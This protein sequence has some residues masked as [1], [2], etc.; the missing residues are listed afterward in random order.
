MKIL[1]CCKQIPDYDYLMPE[2]WKADEQ[3]KVD[4]SFVK[5]IINPCDE[6]ALELTLKLRDQA[7]ATNQDFEIDALSIGGKQIEGMLKS[8]LALQFD[9]VARVDFE[10]NTFSDSIKEGEIYCSYIEKGPLPDII[11]MGQYNPPFDNG[12]AP[13]LIAERLSWP[14][15]SPVNEIALSEETGC[16]ECTS[17]QGGTIYRHTLK[18]LVILVVGNSSRT[19]L[20]IPTLKDKLAASARGIEV[21]PFESLKKTSFVTEEATITNLLRPELRRDCE[22]LKGGIP[23]EQAESILDY[24][25]K[26]GI[27][28]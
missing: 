27:D 16:L 25:E 20:R 26:I 19:Y 9:Q 11:L 28:L 2:D 14:C 22:F 5:T 10:A 8:L 4:C 17:I 24:I 21:I 13:Y 23:A 6:S 15:I 12:V 7:A 1:V 18:P 3:L